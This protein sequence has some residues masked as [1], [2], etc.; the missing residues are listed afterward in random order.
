MT[1]RN[2]TVPGKE[3]KGISPVYHCCFKTSE[4]GSNVKKIFHS[5]SMFIL[6]LFWKMWQQFAIREFSAVEIFNFQKVEVL[7]SCGDLKLDAN[8]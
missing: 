8:I 6:M 1:L 2:A 5:L 4:S 7:C 3:I